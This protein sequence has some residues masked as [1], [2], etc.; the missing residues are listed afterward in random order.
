[1]KL[2]DHL[3]LEEKYNV[4]THF[5]GAALSFF[6]TLWLG[7]HIEAEVVSVYFGTVSYTHL[8]LPTT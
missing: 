3:P 8:T 5:F 4:Y 7:Y 1:M 2:L 6:G